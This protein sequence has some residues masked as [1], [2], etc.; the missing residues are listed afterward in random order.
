MAVSESCP[1]FLEASLGSYSVTSYAVHNIVVCF[2][3]VTKQFS[4]QSSKTESSLRKCNHG[5]NIP[6]SLP[7]SQAE[8][9]VRD[10]THTQAAVIS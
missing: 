3:K 1:Q 6:L 2:F 7:C 4:L 8:E 10:S 5:S 9:H